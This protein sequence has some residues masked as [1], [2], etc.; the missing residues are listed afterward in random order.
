[1]QIELRCALLQQGQQ[2][3][4]PQ[5]KRARRGESWD[6]SRRQYILIKLDKYVN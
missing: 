2:K 6:E 3:Q 4:F 1:M 5:E